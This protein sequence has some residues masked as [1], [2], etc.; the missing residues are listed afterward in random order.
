[1]VERHRISFGG[2]NKL[3]V[4]MVAIF[5]ICEYAQKRGI[6]CLSWV[7]CVIGELGL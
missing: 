3:S 6:V 4:L 2:V 5:H 1:M 7:T